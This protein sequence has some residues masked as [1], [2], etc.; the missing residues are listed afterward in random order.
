MIE[1]DSSARLGRA[2][3]ADDR[4]PEGAAAPKLAEPEEPPP[5]TGSNITK[6]PHELGV[7]IAGLP[8]PSVHIGPAPDVDAVI[9]VRCSLVSPSAQRLLRSLISALHA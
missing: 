2:G 5:A 7:F 3:P 1:L 8:P 9:D 4:M 6:F